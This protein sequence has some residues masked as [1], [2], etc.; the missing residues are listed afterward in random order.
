MTVADELCDRVA[1]LV[2]GR[3]TLIDSPRR[4]KLAHARKVARVEYREG[5]TIASRDFSLD[6]EAS[7]R[8]FV[9]VIERRPIETIHTLE[10]SLEDVFLTVTGRELE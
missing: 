3:I 5:E 8:A 9:E 1:F 4:L 2:E 7:R 6:D 10:P